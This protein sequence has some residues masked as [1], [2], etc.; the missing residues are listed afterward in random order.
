MSTQTLKNGRKPPPDY[1]RTHELQKNLF[2]GE[3]HGLANG[4]EHQNGRVLAPPGHPPPKA[5]PL[6]NR[7]KPLSKQECHKIIGTEFRSLQ[8]LPQ[9]STK[10]VFDLID[11]CLAL[12]EELKELSL[13]PSGLQKYIRAYLL[14]NYF[15]NTYIMHTF[16]GFNSFQEEAPQDFIIYLNL[17]NFFKR[18]DIIGHHVFGIELDALQS[19]IDEYLISRGLL[20]FDHKDLFNW[21]NEYIDYLKHKDDQLDEESED[22][23]D[24]GIEPVT[25][26][27]SKPYYQ[28]EPTNLLN[29][30]EIV[31]QGTLPDFEDEDMFDFANRFPEVSPG[32]VPEPKTPYPVDHSPQRLAEPT[33][34]P[35]RRPEGSKYSGTEPSPQIHRQSRVPEVPPNPPRHIVPP[36]GMGSYEQLPLGPSA[37]SLPTVS[38]AMAYSNNG[39]AFYH[40]NRSQDQLHG[41]QL[42]PYYLSAHGNYQA[43]SPYHQSTAYQ[44]ALPQHYSR[45]PASVQYNGAHLAQY[46]GPVVSPHKAHTTSSAI[47]V[48]MHR[49][50][51]FE[52]M[53][54]AEWLRALSICGLKN[55]GSSCYINLTV[56]VMFGVSRFVSLFSKRS[57]NTA[58]AKA[59]SLS[60][61]PTPLTEALVGLLSTF[62]SSGG[63][64]IAPTKFIRVV[65]M[66]KP[67]FN[68]PFE[69]QDAQEFLL[70][71]LDKLHE[72][73][74]RKPSEEML[75]ID[76]VRRWGIDITPKEKEEY[77]KWYRDLMQAEGVSPI[78][79]LCQGH[80]R[81]QLICDKCGCTSSSYSPFSMLSLPIPNTGRPVI[82]IVDCLRYYTQDEVLSGDNA[83][84]CPRCNKTDGEGNPM[85]VVF[86]QKRSLKP[87]KNKS[88][89]KA[90]ENGNESQHAS[91]KKLS[92]IK[93][94]QVLFIHL[95]RF[96][97]FS[98]T[99]KLNADI[100]YPL[101]LK[102]NNKNGDVTY[103]L[104]GLINH[105]GNLKS[106]HYTSLV[107]KAKDGVDRLSMPEWCY[108][109]DDNFRVHV[110]HGDV[111]SETANK[112]HSR[113]VYVLCYER[114]N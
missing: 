81:S 98:L 4:H 49:T 99:D 56:Q 72:E 59:M 12:F 18:D 52:R 97:M 16:G 68:I 28:T 32:T 71:I 89:K 113:D 109:D 110:P 93:L 106:G 74:S 15:I 35:N 96:S 102:F 105:F 3:V 43:P 8:Q 20:L 47:P 69:Q 50:R 61:K 41:L 111:N 58:L 75:E 14:F 17:Y 2:Q 104:T 88:S 5:P 64:V 37:Q 10:S 42:R 6:P 114:Q 40:S 77:A 25:P 27:V 13:E 33:L 62:Q 103:N 66:L 34:H 112:I 101:R 91:I 31:R 39:N 48:D 108:L 53:Q 55:L 87:W 84:K 51:N 60:A 83:W 85:D 95:S 46:H 23:S 63:A 79:D 65:S 44:S 38:Q 24:Q 70:F 80:V 30:S 22:M 67:S 1:P 82:D 7:Q 29:L 90:K 73:L 107:N 45:H 21:L 36:S 92:I 76:Y 57:N 9:D 78:N 54:K 86:Q 11:T 26:E 94:P 19:Y 100:S